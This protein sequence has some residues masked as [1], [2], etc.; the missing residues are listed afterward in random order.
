MFPVV[1]DCDLVASL[2]L[3]LIVLLTFMD[4]CILTCNVVW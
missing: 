3:L 4:V 1:C 2:C